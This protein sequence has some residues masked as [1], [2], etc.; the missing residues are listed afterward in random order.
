M[1]L[2][3]SS[4]RRDFL[5]SLGVGAAAYGMLP[6]VVPPTADALGRSSARAATARAATARAATAPTTPFDFSWT[7]RLT[8][9]HRAVFDVPNIESAFGVWRASLWGMQYQE[10]MAAKPSDLATVI[11]L[12]AEAI[13]LA[14]NQKYWDAYHVGKT[15]SVKHPI[16][17]QPTDKNPALLS[18][19]RKELPA[20]L[21]GVALDQFMKR[22]G[23]V[24][25]CNV[26]FDEVVGVIAAADKS[27]PDDA[28]KKAVSMVVP[29]ILLQ[30]SG[31]FAVVRAQE[32]GA[33][34]VRAS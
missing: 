3:S 14:M 30:P 32:A 13:S 1:P 27:K 28:H 20:E 15:K 2:S 24:L 26:A 5:Q 12:R 29:G 22:G 11:V 19:A 33:Q 8:T 6:L 21:D 9:K 25:A 17:E 7:N 23:I 16:T 31:V 18:A 4:S 34:Y 10:F